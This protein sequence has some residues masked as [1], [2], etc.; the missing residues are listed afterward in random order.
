MVYV[1]LDVRRFMVVSTSG[2]LCVV[3]RPVV[4]VFAT[5]GGLWDKS[6]PP[7]WIQKHSSDARLLSR[8][9]LCNAIHVFVNMMVT[10]M[11]WGRR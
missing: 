5:S 11:T 2:N 3:R 7:Q 6:G 9:M 8:N 4:Y 10:S 1:C